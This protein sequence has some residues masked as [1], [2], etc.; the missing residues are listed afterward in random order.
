MPTIADQLRQLLSP[1]GLGEL[2][3]AAASQFLDGIVSGPELE[4]WL[5]AQPQVQKR[6]SAVFERRKQG[7]PPISMLD[8]VEY[9]RRANELSSM[10]GLPD[11][12]V[13]VNR[14]LVN[15]I[16]V[17]ELGERVQRA[18]DVIEQ[19][20]D[21][22]EQLQTMYNLGAGD[23]IAYALDPDTGMQAVQRRFAAARVGAQAKRQGFGQLSVGEAES[24][25][26]QV[27][28]DQARDGFATLGKL[29]QVTGRLADEAVDP[30]SRD[31]L[32]GVVAGD[33]PAV[34][35]LQKR[36]ASR[37][38]TFGESSGAQVGGDGV[39]GAGRA[40]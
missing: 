3:D 16:S 14:L 34:T 28:E 23:A 35:A 39:L 21:V 31:A 26:G 32:L 36:Q 13:D 19:R 22:V 30:M 33:Q 18:A 15:D 10:Y 38:A 8:V 27:T 6:F 37:V 9:E 40:K 7:L 11:G 4:L 2:A 12:F 20:P 25:Q 24:L 5:E 29:S 1:Y 17:A